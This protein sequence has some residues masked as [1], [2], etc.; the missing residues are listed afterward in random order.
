MSEP[1]FNNARGAATLTTMPPFDF[2]GVVSRIF[3]LRANIYRLQHF[4]DNYLNKNLPPS[5]G[6]FRPATSHVMFMMIN[7]G[8][9]SSEVADV[10]WVAQNEVLFNI[11]LEWYKDGEK[12]SV[13]HD[14]ATLAPFIYVDA[15]SS[16]ATG[17][18]VYG[19]PKQLAALTAEVN[20]WGRHPRNPRRLLTL[21]ANTFS[22]LGVGAR[23]EMNKLFEIW[24]SPPPTLTQVP[25]D[26]FNLLNPLMAWPRAMANS[27]EMFSGYMDTLMRSP[28]R[29]YPSYGTND[30]GG[31]AAKLLELMSQMGESSGLNTINLK[32]FRGLSDPREACYQSV[33]NSRMEVKR[34]VSGGMLADTDLL[35]GDPSA[36]FRIKVHRTP[37]HP[38]IETLGLEVEE[39]S[40]GVATLRPEFPMWNEV[41]MRYGVGETLAWR[42]GRGEWQI[43]GSSEEAL[44]RREKRARFRTPG[45]SFNTAR[46]GAEEEIG[47]G[48]NFSDVTVRVLPLL[49]A[50]DR[51]QKFV[52]DYLN[53][54]DGEPNQEGYRFEAW[55]SYVYLIV[56]S[57]GEMTST[58]ANIGNWA[59]RG[60]WFS[61]PI[62]WYWAQLDEDGNV[63]KDKKGNELK[64]LVS[65]GFTA[66]YLFVDEEIAATTAREVNG[67]PTMMADIDSPP[68]AWMGL[69]GPDAIH[70][71]HLQM[72]TDV[73]T[74]LGAGQELQRRRVMEIS[75]GDIV[76]QFDY[77]GRML[78][79]T[80]WAP[81]LIETMNDKGRQRYGRTNGEDHGPVDDG[82]LTDLKALALEVFARDKPMNHVSLKQFR[83]SEFP[84]KAC[85]QAVVNQET[86]I[87]QVKDCREIDELLHVELH[88]YPTLPIVETLGLAVKKSEIREGTPVDI[89]QPI[90]PFWLRGHVF[91]GNSH[92]IC[93]RA[94]SLK[95]KVLKPSTDATDDGEDRL[96]CYFAQKP[97][98]I[99]VGRSLVAAIDQPTESDFVHKTDETEIE[100]DEPKD[101]EAGAEGTGFSAPDWR[102]TRGGIKPNLHFTKIV[103]ERWAADPPKDG[104]LTLD[105][106]RKAVESVEPQ[107]A[108]ESIL[109]HEWEDWGNPRWYQREQLR[110]KES[111]D[112]KVRRKGDD[113]ADYAPTMPADIEPRPDVCLRADSVGNVGEDLFKDGSFEIWP[114]LEVD[115]AQQF[116]CYKD[117]TETASAAGD[118]R[119]GKK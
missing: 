66:P 15:T 21:S 114:S 109:S 35:R 14:W 80:Q 6:E 56:N 76:D 26:P 63:K 108:L 117:P 105:Q 90:R 41:D 93:S 75:E 96:D 9:M 60:V 92:E 25:P 65:T 2:D 54:D 59:N 57:Y 88:R 116:L 73:F 17:R 70:R 74:T 101:G 98:D 99:G 82:P 64:E 84:D 103:C 62:K 67:W 23:P 115:R 28:L 20:P 12:G 97:E 79:D 118:S 78:V 45:D 95:W 27:M 107:T 52:D 38:I 51:L 94:G 10:G 42:A 77:R 113:R 30:L 100:N 102:R 37:T 81:K 58:M 29:G 5:V 86:I 50:N 89:L 69:G 43:P 61:I 39:E 36:G 8:R 40:H 22:E 11:P 19:W 7:Y 72:D 33:C 44:P 106:A 16:K 24:H 112:K 3:P 46:G 53:S 111:K 47:G 18:E 49:A 55:G 104:R 4:V 68:S 34:F 1:F 32:Q 48:L 71:G 13:F 110:K 87:K 83:D 85:Y 91:T 119:R 31:Q